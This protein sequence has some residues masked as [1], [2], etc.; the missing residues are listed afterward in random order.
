MRLAPVPDL[1]FLNGRPGVLDEA[2]Q[3]F[4]KSLALNPNRLWAKQQLAK[5]PANWDNN[6]YKLD[7]RTCHNASYPS[8]D[9][10]GK[11]GVRAPGKDANWTTSGHGLASGTYNG[12]G[13][14]WPGA[15]TNPGAM[16][17]A[18]CHD[19]TKVPH[20]S[21]ALN[22]GDRLFVPGDSPVLA[23]TD[24]V[25][26]LCYNC[27]DP[28]QSAARTRGYLAT[29][30]ATV[31]STGVTGKYSGILSP[32]RPYGDNT[33]FATY[34]GYQCAECHDVHGTT[35]IAMVN[36]NIV[37]KVQD[38]TARPVG[39][40]FN[41]TGGSLAGGLDP[42]AAAND[43]VCD[44]CHGTSLNV[45]AHDNT[46]R[47]NNHNYAQNCV[48]CH[49]HDKSFQGS[50]TACHGNAGNGTYWPDNTAA[51][52]AYPNRAGAHDNHITAIYTRN[53]ATLP[54]SDNVS[55][56]NATCDWCHPNPGGGGHDNNTAGSAAS[57]AD[58][59][60]AVNGAFHE[61]STP[62]TT[63]TMSVNAI[64]PARNA[65]TDSSFAPLSTAGAA[66]PAAAA[67]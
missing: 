13:S 34:P 54:G 47:A 62:A 67:A 63:R 6:A 51:G 38:N 44:L 33:N 49:K 31:H 18:V 58:R 11:T 12:T 20:I 57:T 10:A 56:K 48:S 43:G 41:Y 15:G 5:T 7:C 52:A 26:K 40:A 64:L 53:S 59:V 30:K 23:Y 28:A 2:R 45:N 19:Q 21:H 36:D 39:A 16:G 35:K 29:S 50:C 4:G 37:G 60:R 66:P 1:D 25:S 65:R 61:P 46:N 14:P 27:H 55:K 24:N 9:N 17:C 3:A 42:S 32:S 22:D 8:W